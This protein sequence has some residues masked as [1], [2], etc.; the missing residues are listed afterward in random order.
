[1][2]K[3]NLHNLTLVFTCRIDSASRLANVLATIRYYQLYTDARIMLLEADTDSRL[4]T[5]IDSQFPDVDY[6]F[7]KDDNPIFH[8]THYINEEMRRVRTANTANIDV[9]TIVP[10]AQLKAANDLILESSAVMV[11]PYDGRFVCED[12]CRSDMFR[13][14][15][16]IDI[17]EKMPGYTHLMFGYISVGGAYLV[18]VERYKQCGW[19][20]EHF[21]GWGPEDYERFIRLDILGHK[22]MQ[23]PGV[24]YH[25]EHPRGI[26][27]GDKVENVVLATKREYCKVCSMMPDELKD[28]IKTWPW[29]K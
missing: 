23:I 17:F 18:N 9:D 24:I 22:P 12:Q 11:L 3:T 25:L 10:P 28:Y 20:N 7:V 14:T 4:S 27:S 29:V 13:E 5:I 8:R 6:I 21:I 15:P 16:N 19:E 26:N 1:M 2:N